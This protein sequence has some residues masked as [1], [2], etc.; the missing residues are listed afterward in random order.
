MS[1]KISSGLRDHVLATGSFAAGVNGGIIKIYS[2]TVPAT[3]D[4]ALSG[5]TL[6]ATISNNMAGTGINMAATSSAGVLPKAV[7]EVWKGLITTSG[8]AT[9]YRFL[10]IAGTETLS[11]TEKRLQGTVATVGGDLNFSS[12]AF[13]ANGTNSKTVDSF[14][15]TQ[16]TA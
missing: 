15:I 11:T 13:V 5:N 9:F 2:G 8:T 16:P 14:Y 7:A 10:P 12:T 3:A 6:L 1:I 4:A